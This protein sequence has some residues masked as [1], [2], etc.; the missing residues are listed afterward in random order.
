MA[1][2]DKKV[3]LIEIDID[4]NAAKKSVEDLTDSILSQKDAIKGNTDEIKKLNKGT[5]EE[6]KQAKELEKQN[7]KLRDELKDLNAQRSQAVKATKL[8]SNSLDALRKKVVS[9]K[10][11]L[12]GLN[13][14]T[15]QGRKRFDELSASLKE[16]NERIKELDQGAGD[17]KTSVGDYPDL[18]GDVQGGFKGLITTAKAFIATPIGLVVGALAAAFGLVQN[19]LNRSEKTTNKL[20]R[21]FAPLE[22]VINLV[23]KGLEPLG[24]FLIDGIVKGFELASKAA[25][26]FTDALADGLDFLGFDDAANSVREFKQEVEEAGGAAIKLA[27]AEAKL[28]EE[29]RKQERIQLEFQRRA[30]KLRQIRDDESKSIEERIEANRQ[31]GQVLQEQSTREL[32]I[33]N[34][35]LSV[36]DQ[37]IKMEG[38]TTELLDERAEALTKVAEINERITGQESEQLVNLNSLRKE[39][40]DLAQEQLEL[41]RQ[42]EEERLKIEKEAAEKREENLIV[43]NDRLRE[44]EDFRRNQSFEAQLKGLED[45]KKIFD[46]KSQQEEE[47]FKSE[48]EALKEQED[49]LE[50]NTELT[51][52]ERAIQKAD[53]DLAKEEAEAEHNQRLLDIEKEFDDKR[54]EQE[55]EF[56]K[57][58]I[59]V[60]KTG[61]KAVSGVLESVNNS[62]SNFYDKRIKSIEDQLK[63]GQI[64][65]EEAA[66]QIQKLE[67]DKAFDQWRVDKKKFQLQK[68]Q[69]LAGVGIDIARA[70]TK[71][72][73][74]TPLTFGQ[75]FGGAAIALGAIQTAAILSRKAPP[76]PSFAEGGTVI[77]GPSHAQGGQ[78]IYVGGRR[79]GNMQGGEGLFVTKREATANALSFMNEQAGGRSFFGTSSRY[80]QEGGRVDTSQQQGISK[81]EIIDIMQSLPPLEVQATSVMGAVDA[82]QKANDLGVV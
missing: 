26:F 1:D 80:L 21:A 20:R 82:E 65:E 67:R 13:T 72:T 10:K 71:S 81:Q 61:Q 69:D 52:E 31:L 58:N 56:Q 35:A 7:F 19:A 79:V 37:R 54:L 49:R 53:L 23:L 15:E 42:E 68:I 36:I 73:A 55:K 12:N 40:N 76:P 62:V 28:R 46:L 70:V 57:E 51:A 78:D 74:A 32:E 14:A 75:P 44:L 29:L 25:S 59:D 45:D 77:N 43:L 27:D 6:Q 4:Q 34:L 47:N 30:E 50:E 8:Q 38:E 60:T 3:A 33:A 24:E 22:G 64:N 48:L 41:K 63:K 39:Q 2:F 9:Q 66:K 17:F 11:E 18:L 5:E 16:N